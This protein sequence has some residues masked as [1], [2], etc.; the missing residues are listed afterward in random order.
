M[1]RADHTADPE[2]IRDTV[3][4]REPGA[5]SHFCD[6]TIVERR[7]LVKSSPI[8]A[9]TE[10][11]TTTLHTERERVREQMYDPAPGVPFALSPEFAQPQPLIPVQG[12]PDTPAVDPEQKRASFEILD[13]FHIRR[14]VYLIHIDLRILNPANVLIR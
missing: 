1:T 10:P 8:G 4:M 3:P 9:M 14:A 11:S 13:F 6:R 5:E 7:S 12:H 2:R